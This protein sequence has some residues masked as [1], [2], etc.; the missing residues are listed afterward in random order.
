MR[1]L[2]AAADCGVSGSR[3]PRPYRPGDRGQ[4]AGSFVRAL[5]RLYHGGAQLRAMAL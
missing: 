5:Y 4:H 1:G 2:G 3:P